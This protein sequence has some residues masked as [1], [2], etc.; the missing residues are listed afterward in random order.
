MPA[1]AR[2]LRMSVV[3]PRRPWRATTGSGKDPSAG[4]SVRIVVVRPRTQMRSMEKPR[5]ATAM[6]IGHGDPGE[7]T[8]IGCEIC[9]PD[10]EAGDCE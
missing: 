5:S 8:V 2:A 4:V 9:G 1:A 6:R 7:C 10:D 3:A